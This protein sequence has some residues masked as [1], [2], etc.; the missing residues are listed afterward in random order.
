MRL[1]GRH[2]LF[3][4]KGEEEKEER[5]L[6]PH[7]HGTAYNLPGPPG[8]GSGAAAGYGTTGLA[9]VAAAASA[10]AMFRTLTRRRRVCPLSPADTM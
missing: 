1:R 9:G 3:P 10:P 7:R 2:A 6:G 4:P 5:E 8:P